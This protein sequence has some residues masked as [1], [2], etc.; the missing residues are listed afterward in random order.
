MYIDLLERIVEETSKTNDALNN[1]LEQ[2]V[3]SKPNEQ[4]Q[5]SQP[6]QVGS[7]LS[8][9]SV[10][11]MIE[12]INGLDKEKSKSIIDLVKSISDIDSKSLSVNSESL[13]STI[14]SISNAINKVD[15]DK[16]KIQSLND[17]STATKGILGTAAL[18]GIATPLLSISAIGSFLLI[19][20][21]WSLSKAFS[22]LTPET[23][24]SM[25]RGGDALKSVGIGL[26]AF[27]GSLGLS[28]LIL[29]TTLSGS[30][31]IGLMAAFGFMALSAIVFSLIGEHNDNIN[32][33]SL[34]VFGMGLSLLAFSYM[35]GISSNNVADVGLANLG[36]LALAL[37]GTAIIFGIAGE[38][39]KNILLG[40]LAFAAIGISLWIISSP[41]QTISDVMKDNSDM[42]WK[43][44]I[45][46]TALGGVYALAGIPVVAGFMVLGAL[47]FAAVGASLI[48]LSFGLKKLNEVG[49]FEGDKFSNI[50]SGITG[51]FNQISLKDTLTIPFKI[52]AILSMALALSTLGYG[53]ETYKDA[54]GWSR[55]NADEFNYS[56]S[57]FA[58]AFSQDGIDWD[59]VEDGIDAT[60]D[61]GENLHK[62]A[63]GIKAWESLTFD[64]EL[65]KDNVST[66]LNTLPFIFSEIGKSD[67]AGE[68]FFG[69]GQ[70]DVEKGISSTMDMGENLIKLADG[71]K[72]WETIDFD[73][74]LV[75][76]NVK[77][78][79]DVIPSLFASVG[80][81]D[82]AGESFFG[83]GQGDVEKGISSTMGLGKNLI[84]LADGIKAWQVIDFDIGTVRTN[85]ASILDVIPSLFASVGRADSETDGFFDWGG[86]DIE[87]GIGL[88]NDLSAPLKTVSDLISSLSSSSETGSDAK[89][90]GLSISY[91]FAGL[92][93]GLKLIEIESIVKLKMMAD[94]L[95]KFSKSLPLFNKN[96]GETISVLNTLDKDTIEK[97]DLLTS[98]MENLGGVKSLELQNKNINEVT[99]EV[100]GS[101]NGINI[102]EVDKAPS[103]QPSDQP[104]VSDNGD[105]NGSTKLLSAI[106]NLSTLLT[107]INSS[108]SDNGSS[109][110]KINQRLNKTIKVKNS[111]DI[112]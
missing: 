38:F 100:I 112:V 3:S 50:I 8:S 66:V 10:E 42:L 15:L 67:E 93:N 89:D 94:P 111:N 30:G 99:H 57:S 18:I 103:D 56:I 75:R 29:G 90:L 68:G 87:K 44:P 2:F 83:W 22:F 12:S 79:L 69:W 101:V 88:V 98:A 24:D 7:P 63:D 104:L 92:Q 55:E 105:A 82:E 110:E 97:F 77:S 21:M 19:P 5:G 74:N 59:D 16:D 78:I 43:L 76:T 25:D 46:L 96:L 108:V 40:S 106:E 47:A 6:S 23:L 58:E 4:P 33:G 109:L 9:G 41:L 61:L 17:L 20:I 36:L 91:M 53:M 70:G 52:P 28:A 39:A 1:I 73:I 35:L 26:L 102:P 37:G 85:I 51:G 84:D 27:S 54:G 13:T 107:N 45:M 81:E 48:P 11:S 34:S 64:I 49:D 60:M 31:I 86:G 71:I 62:L 65:V 80:R 14:S 32:K 72:A 95:S